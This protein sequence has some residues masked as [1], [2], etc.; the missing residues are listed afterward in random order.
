MTSLAKYD[1][2]MSSL[3]VTDCVSWSPVQ[4][5]SSMLVLFLNTESELE[6]GQL[7]SQLGAV[8]AEPTSL[9]TTGAP[10]KLVSFDTATSPVA[11]FEIQSVL[12][13]VVT[14]VFES[15]SNGVTPA[16][17]ACT[18]EAGEAAS[19]IATG[20]ASAA[21][22]IRRKGLERNTCRFMCARSCVRRPSAGIPDTDWNGPTH[23][24]VG[25]WS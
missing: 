25:T 18:G 16:S 8:F 5:G 10:V 19:V 22:K 3:G 23:A 15:I 17:A 4:L 11:A 24:P 6:L 14:T 2:Q 12:P 21:V 9:C 1:W 13:T 20:A 7:A